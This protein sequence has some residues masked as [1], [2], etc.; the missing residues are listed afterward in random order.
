[1]YA[2]LKEAF[3]GKRVFLTGHTGFKG[4]WMLLMLKELGAEVKG[5][6]LPPENNS[7]LYNALSGDKLCYASVLGD[8]RNFEL[9]RGEIVRFQPHY[10]FHLAAQSLV[11]RSY[12]TPL[13]TFMVNT[14]GTAHILE[15]L[16]GVPF[17][18]TTVIV[19]T[20]IVT[21][22]YRRSFFHPEQY[23]THQKAIAAA[24]AGN[25]IGGGDYAEDRIV[26]DII[27]AIE[28]NTMVKLRNPQSVRPWQHV[29]EPLFAY[30]L[31]AAKLDT[32][33]LRYS[34]AYNFGPEH[35][36]QKTVEELTQIFLQAYGKEGLYQNDTQTNHP[37]EAGL[38]LL[39][40]TRAQ[41]VLNWHPKLNAAS[42]I[43]WTAE[44]YADKT[45]SALDKCKNQ[46]QKYLEL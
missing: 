5:F 33:P 1:M 13:E 43:Y 29:L 28:S 30:L 26:P 40:S 15:A 25:V 12:S 32:D 35:H 7:D 22:S 2:L 20:E 41:D 34:G 6:S 23:S 46:I 16:R 19:T 3:Q 27:R 8:I 9:L 37:H 31:L 10:I 36:D 21:D 42:A 44:W 18:I 4:A 14:I 39:D 11:R 17:P 24:R 45:T 38:L